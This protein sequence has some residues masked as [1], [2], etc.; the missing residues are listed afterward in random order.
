MLRVSCAVFVVA[1]AGLYACGGGSKAERGTGS[2]NM[3]RL[4][5]VTAGDGHIVEKAD[6]DGDGNPDVWSEFAI[7]KEE[8]SKVL[9]KKATDVNA[10]GKVDVAILF[11]E[12]GERIRE[13]LDMDY[14]GRVDK[15]RNF[16]KGKIDREDISSLFDGKFDIRKYY[17]DGVLVLKQVDAGHDGTFDEFQYFVGQKLSRIGWDRDGD[18]KPEVFEENP[19]MQQ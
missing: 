13:E 18:G 5:T 1:I 8:G 4:M 10:D 15:V 16:K 7:G 17:E 6:L 9:V 14:D 3:A 2:D 12:T 19:A 11:D